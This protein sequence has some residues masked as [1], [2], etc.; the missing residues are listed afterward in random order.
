MHQPPHGALSGV[1]VLDCADEL[2]AYCSNLLAGLGADVIRVSS[3]AGTRLAEATPAGLYLNAGKRC[4]TFDPADANDRTWLFELARSADVVVETGPSGLLSAAGI[5]REALQEANPALVLTRVTPLG[6]DGPDGGRYASDLT[7]MARG[8]LMWLAGDPDA[9]PVRPAGHQSVVAA[10]LY[11]AIGTL[12][13][14]LHSEST[15]EGQRVEVAA[16]E[17][18]ASALEN[19]VQ[20]WDLEHTIRKRAG[21]K[22]REAGSG[23]YPCR[24]GYV[25]M[26]AGRLSTPR[27]W[28][29]VVEWLNEAGVPGAAELKR[30]EWSSY[31]YRTRPDATALFT[32]LFV[33]FAA[34]RGKTELYEEGQ[35]RG[36]VICPLNTPLD[37]LTDRQLRHRRFF[38]PLKGS[39]LGRRVLFPRGPFVLSR[40]P[41]RTAPSVALDA[42]RGGPEWRAAK[43]PVP[44]RRAAPSGGLPLAGIRVADF[45]W[46][47]AGPFA[48]KILAD[49]G[50]EVIKIE[51]TTRIEALRVIPPYRDKVSGVNR[52]GYFANRNTSKK[53][54]TLNLRDPGGVDLARGLIAASDIVANSFA[55]GTME[56]WGLGYEDCRKLRSDIIY[57]SMP[58][59]GND[60]PHGQYLGYGAAIGALSGLYASTGYSDRDPV[61]TGTNYPDH[62]PNPGHAAVAMLSALRHR[63]RTGEGQAIE[64]SQVESTIYALGPLV[65]AAQLAEG[66]QAN[67]LRLGNREPGVAP[68]GVYPAAGDD[69]WLAIACWSEVEWQA[70]CRAAGGESWPREPRFAS[71]AGRLQ[72]EDELDRALA[73]WSG[74]H[75]AF[76][77]AARLN[78]AGVDAA[79]VQHAQDVVERDPQLRY[80]GHWVRL[81]HPEMGESVYDAP[82]FRL[83]ATPGRLR[84]PAPLLGEHTESICHDL[85]GISEEEVA[86]LIAG[87]VLK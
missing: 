10:G 85:L 23:L 5:A 26:M 82:P 69:R 63:Q 46:V 41:F 3:A 40:T 67:A 48:T 78:D 16:L 43:A 66:A 39:V 76:E 18:I 87:G 79:P 14:L 80:L 68:H 62:V 33:G 53:S 86:G 57:L 81:R 12:I 56:K 11:A 6:S 24:D 49:H 38:V 19:A 37:L 74:R 8:G 29:S 55:P 17:C 77:L 65:L 51:S 31:D 58:M 28:I 60:G 50:A 44:R 21:S 47:G 75:D 32:K 2:G 25:Y 73:R 7:L 64:L 42:T 52:S 13:A 84:S 1:R 70:L 54:L 27:G 45:T 30:S 72:H 34:E 4:V 71:L 35:A 59:N 15:K 36:I 22:P 61:G 83:S 20:Y 9:P